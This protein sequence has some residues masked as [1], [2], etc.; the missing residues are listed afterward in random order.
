[1]RNSVVVL[2]DGLYSSLVHYAFI[3]ACFVLRRKALLDQLAQVRQ[4][5]VAKQVDQVVFRDVSRKVDH[6]LLLVG[7]YELVLELTEDLEQLEVECL[8]RALETRFF[9]TDDDL[10]EDLGHVQRQ[11]L[12][13]VLEE[14]VD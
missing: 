6:N 3:K 14:L 13:V 7:S 4:A 5:L 12:L 8:L 10:P 11:E 1:M 9:G 2:S